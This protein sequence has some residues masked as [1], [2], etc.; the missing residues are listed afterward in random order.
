[1]S[2]PERIKL[3]EKALIKYVELYGFIDEAR[4][5]YIRNSDAKAPSIE[6]KH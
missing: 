5:Y 2:D 6:Q 3:L 1:M 4:E